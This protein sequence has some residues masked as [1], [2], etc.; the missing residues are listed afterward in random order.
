MQQRV[1][2]YS[3]GKHQKLRCWIALGMGWVG[4][5]VPGQG[6]GVKDRVRMHRRERT[7]EM[8]LCWV[9][10]EMDWVGP[11]GKGLG[12]GLGGHRASFPQMATI[13]CWR[14]QLCSAP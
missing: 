14:L 3:E 5:A 1:R 2:V 13:D 6:M 4:R 9:A 11:A 10:L 8:P 7:C 12:L